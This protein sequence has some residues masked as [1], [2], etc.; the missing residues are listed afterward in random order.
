MKVKELFEQEEHTAGYYSVMFSDD[1]IHNHQSEFDKYD[2]EFKKTTWAGVKVQSKKY[3]VIKKLCNELGSVGIW[4]GADEDETITSFTQ[5]P[6]TIESGFVFNERCKFNNFKNVHKHFRYIRGSVYFDALYFTSNI[7][8]FLKIPEIS[9]ID[10]G[11]VFR[12]RHNGRVL[13]GILN[14]ALDEKRNLLD[15]QQE[16]IEAGFEEYAQL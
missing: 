3:D 15:V 14:T 11:S 10:V 5:F 8:G 4:F 1:F 9:R 13:Q 6:K 12:Q 7:L 2:V 16:L